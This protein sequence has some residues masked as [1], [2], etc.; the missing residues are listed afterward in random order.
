MTLLVR[1][2]V[3]VAPVA[4][5]LRT[6]MRKQMYSVKYISYSRHFVFSQYLYND[7]FIYL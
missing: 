7:L 4:L 2:C 5:I 3:L 6:S 1:L